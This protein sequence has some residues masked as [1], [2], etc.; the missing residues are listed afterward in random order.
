M[1][2]E[3]QNLRI[4]FFRLASP[5]IANCLDKIKTG[6]HKEKAMKSRQN[7]TYYY[8][9]MLIIDTPSVRI[10]CNKPELIERPQTTTKLRGETRQQK[11][12]YPQEGSNLGTSLLNL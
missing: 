5:K 11:L 12:K 9:K 2:I 10:H 1:C 4:F 7:Y 6:N 3:L 8:K